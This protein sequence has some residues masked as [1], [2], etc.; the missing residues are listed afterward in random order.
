M[1]GLQTEECFEK[2]KDDFKCGMKCDDQSMFYVD[3]FGYVG[4]AYGWSKEDLI[5]KEMWAWGPVS[6]DFKV[7][8]SFYGY[9]EGVF[10]ESASKFVEGVDFEIYKPWSF[11]K[12]M[13]QSNMEKGIEW[14]DVNHAV[15]LVGW[16]EVDHTDGSSTP[17]WIIQNSWDEFWGEEGYVYVH[18]GINHCGVES[19]ST[20]INPKL[21]N[22]YL[23]L[24]AV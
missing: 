24:S 3:S 16:G 20:Y 7:R 10:H 22:E 15:L 1:F 12:M 5:M 13:T 23:N 4:G 2:L 19:F 18:R 14:E 8:E 6:V 9:D 17:Y 21:P 11:V